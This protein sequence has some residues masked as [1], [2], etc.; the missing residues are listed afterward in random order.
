MTEIFFITLLLFRAGAEPPI[1]VK[2]GETRDRDPVENDR[3]FAEKRD[4]SAIDAG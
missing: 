1:P 4:D 2:R 3:F